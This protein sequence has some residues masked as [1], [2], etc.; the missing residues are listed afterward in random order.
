MRFRTSPDALF[1]YENGLSPEIDGGHAWHVPAAL[2]FMLQAANDRDHP[3]LLILDEMNLAHVERYFADVLSGM[4]SGEPVLPNLRRNEKGEWRAVGGPVALPENLMV[5][6]T[7]NV[8]E[9][10]Y[11]FSPKVLD[12]ANT[13]EFRVETADLATDGAPLESIDAGNL[14]HARSFL[15]IA[16]TTA[17]PASAHAELAGHLRELHTLLASFGREF[18]HRTFGEAL[19]FAALLEQSGDSDPLV[20][21]DLQV[22]QKVLPKFHGSVREIAEPLALLA[23]WTFNGPGVAQGDGKFDAISPP[24]SAEPALPMTF[25]KIQRMT[26]RLQANHFVSFAE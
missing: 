1:G 19:R 26:K 18:G 5:V 23:S 17:V 6:G 10:T 21:L 16:S 25:A 11:M 22:L 9:T 8:D 14:S 7:V 3:Y 4:E 15:R 20:A 24:G 12:R 2:E 13:I